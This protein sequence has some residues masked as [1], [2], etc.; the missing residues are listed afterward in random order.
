MVTQRPHRTLGHFVLRFLLNGP[1]RI[2][3]VALS[4]MVVVVL[5]SYQRT[6]DRDGAV[7]LSQAPILQPVTALDNLSELV[8]AT[9]LGPTT[10]LTQPDG[11]TVGLEHDLT[12]KFGEA[13]GKPVR[14]LVL[15]NMDQVLEAVRSR[16]AHFAAA[17]VHVS[18]PLKK[19]FDFTLPYQQSRPQLVFN[20]SLTPAPASPAD[21][22]GKR[23]G[24]VPDPVHLEIL[25][26][27][28]A[29]FPALSWQAFPHGDLDLD[30][31]QKVFEGSIQ[32]AVSDSNTIAIAQNYYPDLTVAFDLGPDEP[33]AWAFLH[34][35]N[36]P[37]YQAARDYLG[38]LDHSGG[39]SRAV[40]RYYGHINALDHEDASAFLQKMVSRLPRFS[41]NFK[42]AQ[43]LS[44]VDWRL[45][46]AIAYQ[47][48]RWDNDAISPTGVRGI[49]MLTADT[50]DR[51][52]VSNRMDPNQ[53]IPAAAQYLQQLKDMVPP[54][55]PEPD[56]TWLALAA[57]NVG[58]AHLED[59]RILAQ[60]NKLNPDSWN[61]I[62]KM[63]PLLSLPA[64]Y[65]TTKSGFARGGEPVNFVENVRGY[66]DILARFEKPHHPIAG[67]MGGL[68]RLVG[69]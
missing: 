47:E 39:L 40:E 15:D 49:M 54:R 4:L 64:V 24:V 53:A 25:K 45:L 27:L 23:V 32:Y 65:E 57:Y 1:E 29:Q 44:S 48:S 66:Y 41:G 6:A 35:E 16:R 58:F 26:Q 51:L 9:R 67:M 21:L 69:P 31:L 61:D 52:H 59:A 68:S 60:R 55:I 17:A 33:I 20:A 37:L 3:I 12:L 2:F 14:F 46:A 62:K 43:E 63:L 10:Y 56:R 38:S 19:Q 42:R 36:T 11:R 5:W 30:L 8:V 28:K 18:P 7:I 34:D 22:V 50:A 13:L